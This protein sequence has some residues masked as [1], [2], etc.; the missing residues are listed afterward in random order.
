MMQVHSVTRD[1]TQCTTQMLDLD[2][3]VSASEENQYTD[4]INFYFF[5]NGKLTN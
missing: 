3:L 5:L 2:T 1:I 4:I